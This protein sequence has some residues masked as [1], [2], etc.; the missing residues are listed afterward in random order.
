[1]AA[2]GMAKKPLTKIQHLSARI[3]AQLHQFAGEPDGDQS[4]GAL[5]D[6]NGSM[7]IDASGRDPNRVKGS[8]NNPLLRAGLAGGAVAG[9]AAIVAN[10]DKIRAGYQN[11]RAGMDAGMARAK[12]GVAAARTA[13]KPYTDRAVAATKSGMATATDAA[14]TAGFRGMRGGAEVLK[15]GA[16][17]AEKAALPTVGGVLKKGAKF[18]RKN[19]MK[20]FNA[21][22]AQTLVRLERKMSAL[23][24]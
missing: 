16:K 3:E 11:T 21:E 23:G 8:F 14:K 24:A 6:Q 2:V 18:L 20:L 1:M 5:Y 13:V 4:D 15:K 17:A 9:A 10:K 19:S 12:T 7:L 22:L